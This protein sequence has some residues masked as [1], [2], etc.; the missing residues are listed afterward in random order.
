MGHLALDE[1]LLA[2][3]KYPC[4]QLV[5]TETLIISAENNPAVEAMERR[6]IAGIAILSLVITWIVLGTL[7]VGI[8]AMALD[9]KGPRPM[10]DPIDDDP[11]P[12]PQFIGGISV[13]GDPIDDDPNPEPQIS[14]F[15]P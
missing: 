12:E 4:G 10:G 14:S 1:F 8:N 15:A 9:V 6:F 3:H 13:L 11:N 7:V 5:V 2:F